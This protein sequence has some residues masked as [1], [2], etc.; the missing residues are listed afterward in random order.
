[1]GKLFQNGFTGEV[2]ASEEKKLFQN[3]FS[4]SRY[5]TLSKTVETEAS[6]TST[7]PSLGHQN[8]SSHM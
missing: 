1:M 6:K 2:E 7:K 8:S 3:I 5:G 4:S